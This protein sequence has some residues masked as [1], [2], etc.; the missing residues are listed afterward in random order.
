MSEDE[1]M[2]STNRAIT[3]ILSQEEMNSVMQYV[4]LGLEL[5]CEDGTSDAE[6]L[7]GGAYR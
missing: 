2:E 7:V 3:K 1:S 4:L 6:F 5:D